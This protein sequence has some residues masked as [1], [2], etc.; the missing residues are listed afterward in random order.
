M[1]VSSKRTTNAIES[2]FAAL[3]Q[4]TTRTRNCVS[5][6]TFLGLAIKLIEETEKRWRRISGPEQITLLL[7][8]SSL[9]TANR[10][11]RSTGSGETCR[12][13]SDAIK[14]SIRSSHASSWK[15]SPRRTQRATFTALRPHSIK[16][17]ADTGRHKPSAFARVPSSIHFVTEAKRAEP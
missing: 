5:R 13:K 16:R 7:E 9:R 1:G 3:R 14:P 8:G 2:A 17:R 15:R 4:R 10:A 12:L 11:R 6:L